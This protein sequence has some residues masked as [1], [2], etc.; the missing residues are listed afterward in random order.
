MGGAIVEATGLTEEECSTALENAIKV[1]VAMGLTE[2]RS[3]TK[4]QWD[5][6]S[7]LWIA[8]AWMHA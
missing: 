6:E 5:E 1:A 3:V 7:Q 8:S 2:R 4:P